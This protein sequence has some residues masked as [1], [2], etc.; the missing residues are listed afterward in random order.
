M[1]WENHCSFSHFT[2]ALLQIAKLYSRPSI[3]GT[4]R[5]LSAPVQIS[6]FTQKLQQE[7]TR[8]G[9]PARP[10]S[11]PQPTTP[12]VMP[13]NRSVSSWMGPTR[14]AASTHS[15]YG[16]TSETTS[17]GRP[18]QKGEAGSIWVA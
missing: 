10:R 14:L 1:A 16:C 6:R 4:P 11:A 9:S 12:W 18:N 8:P 15:S 17:G 3:P 13:S 5:A 2:V 7:D